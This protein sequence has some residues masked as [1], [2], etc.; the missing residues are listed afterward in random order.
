MATEEYRENPQLSPFKVFAEE[1]YHSRQDDLSYS[2]ARQSLQDANDDGPDS[3]QDPPSSPFQYNAREDTVDFAKLREMTALGGDGHSAT[4][5][6]R[7]Y[8]YE[9]TPDGPDADHT[10]DDRAK[11]S[12]GER[13]VPNISVCA[14]EDDS[15]VHE[16]NM[17]ENA[18]QR[19][20]PDISVRADED[21]SIV[22]EQNMAENAGQ[23]DVPDINVCADGDSSVVH[24]QNMAESTGQE[25]GNSVMEDK[26]NEGMSTVL[27]G[28]NTAEDKENV[29]SNG[30]DDAMIDDSHDPMDD[31]CHSTFSAIPDMTSMTSFAQLRRD[32]PMKAMR[33]SPSP[34]QRS[35]EPSTPSTARRPY[36]KNAL[37]DISS[38]IGSP[39]PRRREGK[40]A[41]NPSETPNLL[42]FDDQPNLLP[43]Q[44]YGMQNAQGS[45]SRRS[46]LRTLRESIR[47]PVKGSLLDFDASPA[48]TPKS[49]PTITPRELETLKSGFMSEISSLKATLSGREA[50]VTSLKQAVTD[51]ERRVGEALEE[52]RNEAARKESLEMEQ[53]EWNRR[54][55]EMEEVLRS[56][57]ADIV[58]G[59]QEKEGLTK[60]VEE[61]EKGKE[62][63]EG[64]IVE[65]EGRLSAARNPASG[66][67]GASGDTSHAK[68]S[69]ETAKEVKDAVDNVSL[70]LHMLYKGK[71]ET[72]VAAL[73]KSY[74]SRWDKRVKEAENKLKAVNE[75]NER[76]KAERPK[77]VS[78]APNANASM[79]A[80]EKD[81]HEAEKRV[82]DAQ[83]KGLQ[84][85]MATIREDNGRLHAD[86]KAERTEK[87][88]LVAA[89]DEW[90]AMQQKSPQVQ[91]QRMSSGSPVSQEVS[92]ESTPGEAETPGVN[93]RQNSGRSGIRPPS[94]GSNGEKKIPKV[95]AT[96]GKPG[97]GNSGGRSGIA[98]PT[99][100]RGGI[101][102]S[103]ERMGRGGI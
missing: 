54:G 20:V 103:I 93:S 63:L 57:K 72:K 58:E 77:T 79:M 62:H 82:L 24:E 10:P 46:P 50:E 70:E 67:N 41:G 73:K 66:E 11:K 13:D 43:R 60:K 90:L 88:E 35:V 52:V 27:H 86:L 96:P 32:S 53:A 64:R 87:G 15:I 2:S 81:E 65:L 25:V 38:P 74:E 83:I 22:H 34:A 6:K 76:L 7:S 55:Q 78:E 75:E 23:R 61:A 97:R 33:N 56:V 12:A 21:S 99:P 19:D 98:V 59:E 91:Q 28:E 71:H 68:T 42:D 40:G 17:A 45:P 85:E 49:V 5:R 26:H 100:G 3:F 48:P 36:R 37:L 16:Q 95:G 84:Q 1:T 18:G 89:V 39:T 47:S 9:Y 4:P 8:E 51:A 14:D 29:D 30:E 94:T 44:R 31:T 92:R 101:M 69:E 80:H 102:S